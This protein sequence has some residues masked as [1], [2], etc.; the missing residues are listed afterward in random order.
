MWGELPIL[1]RRLWTLFLVLCI[2][3]APL[4]FVAAI[5][6]DL[7]ACAAAKLADVPD[8]VYRSPR[9]ATVEARLRT[10]SEGLVTHDR[11]VP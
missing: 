7:T 10:P 6:G 4:A 9:C 11:P 1:R 3:M 2:P 5:I 8:F